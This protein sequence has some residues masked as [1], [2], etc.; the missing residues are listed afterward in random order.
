[1][2]LILDAE[3]AAIRRLIVAGK[4]RGYVT[5]HKMNATLP[6]GVAALELVEDTLAI[7][8]D[9]GITILKEGPKD[10]E[11][12]PREPHGLLGPLPLQASV[13]ASFDP[14]QTDDD[15]GKV[16]GTMTLEAWTP[17][18][19]RLI[20]RGR[21]VG[22]VTVAEVNAALLCTNVSAETVKA[23]LAAL[24]EAGVNVIEGEDEP[25]P[26]DRSA[27]FEGKAG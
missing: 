26:D 11:A 5:V 25:L 20:I 18:V 21:V 10:G 27:A 9:F 14:N 8:R 24:S 19:E 23:P 6:S 2:E 17:E 4:E 13:E 12:A 16:G 7:L 3:A 22:H 15:F 1:M